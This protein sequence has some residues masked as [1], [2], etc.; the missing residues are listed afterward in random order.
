MTEEQNEYREQSQDSRV[1]GTGTF[2]SVLPERR[3]KVKR[4]G[5]TRVQRMCTV[6]GV[7]CV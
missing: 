7:K 6:F 2:S 4:K 1:S 5:T 3:W